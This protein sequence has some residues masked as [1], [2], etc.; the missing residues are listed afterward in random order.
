LY[1]RAK[2]VVFP[3]H[4]E[5]FGLPVLHALGNRKVIF[6]RDL[7]VYDEI[8][9]RISAPENIR[10]FKTKQDLARQ[11]ADGNFEWK[12]S[13]RVVT[14]VGWD[15]AARELEAE[16]VAAA[17][18]T[19][20]EKIQKRLECL[21]LLTKSLDAHDQR[22]V[23]EA[24]A[25]AIRKGEELQQAREELNAVHRSTSWRLTA[26]LR[27]LRGRIAGASEP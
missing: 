23:E 10:V 20:V 27:K 13:D 5:G 12:V 7:P 26:P 11:L 19:S 2:A 8:R 3:S 4:Y 21:A 22:A 24:R 16:F 14:D 25:L 9:A 1:S 15:R 17:R 6:V 18:S